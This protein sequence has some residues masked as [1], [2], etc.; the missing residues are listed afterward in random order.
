MLV[1][2]S[3]QPPKLASADQELPFGRSRKF[4]R[5]RKTSLPRL[6]LEEEDLFLADAAQLSLRK[7]FLNAD[8]PGA[9]GVDAPNLRP[10]T[11]L[12]DLD[13][14]PAHGSNRGLFSGDCFFADRFLQKFAVL[15]V[16]ALIDHLPGYGVGSRAK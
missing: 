13:A 16:F 15:S 12:D 2:K 3:W 10:V 5:P 8:G 7:L 11:G 4:V 14:H 1:W 6:W 9:E